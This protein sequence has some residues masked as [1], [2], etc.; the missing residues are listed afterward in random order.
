MNEF[1]CC[2]C[3]PRCLAVALGRWAFGILF[4]FAGI[5]KIGNP[6]GFAKFLLGQ[7]EKT[8]LPKWLLTP[9]GYALPFI[10]LTLG[11]LLLLGIARNTVLFVTGLLLLTLTFGQIV[12][13]SPVAF[14]NLMYALG[15]AAVLF[16][17]EYDY[18]VLGGGS[19][20]K[21]PERQT[22]LG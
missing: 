20:P 12:L 8:W 18:W 16:L 13:Q 10:E 6:A 14:N 2:S 15:V 9:F 17:A 22:G 3:D 1:K 19:R 11:I 7:Y 21:L 4:L 5:G